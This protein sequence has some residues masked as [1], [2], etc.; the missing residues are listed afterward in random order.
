MYL[1]SEKYGYILLKSVFKY[2]IMSVS[3]LPK[4]S[5]NILILLF[6]IPISSIDNINFFSDITTFWM[7]HS[8]GRCS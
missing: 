2:V 3:Q 1:F 5:K 7:V 6:M 8:F 4:V